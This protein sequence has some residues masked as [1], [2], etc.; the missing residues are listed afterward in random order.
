MTVDTSGEPAPVIVTFETKRVGGEPI[1]FPY[2][3]AP[4]MT[5]EV[6][7]SVGE[8]VA[9]LVGVSVEVDVG[10]NVSVAVA[11]GVNVSVAVAVGVNVFVAVIVGV[12]VFVAVAVGVNVFVAVA[13]GVNVFVA[14]G[15]G[16]NVFVAVGVDV[17]VRVGVG[18]NVLVAVGVD[19][20]VRVGVNVAVEVAVTVAV[21]VGVNVGVA[22][23]EIVKFAADDPKGATKLCS[24]TRI[25]AVPVGEFGT[26]HDLEPV[27]ATFDA[28]VV[29]NVVPPFVESSMVTFLLKPPLFVHV[30]LTFDPTITVF[31]L[32]ET[33]VIV[34]GVRSVVVSLYQPI[35][36]IC[37]RVRSRS[38]GIPN[39]PVET[40]GSIK[41]LGKHALLK[42]ETDDPDSYGFGAYN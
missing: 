8:L 31:P 4:E 42:W 25:R 1:A 3:T 29:G 33:F 27:L 11:V 39:A 15:V 10:V 5:G 2:I 20:F 7:V 38:N 17:F 13:V 34:S 22:L 23:V 19:V 21:F 32:G 24:R 30:I 9:V 12:N 40:P 6:G 36:R 41:R 14:V 37:W 28:M 35:S 26:V 18:V 16:V